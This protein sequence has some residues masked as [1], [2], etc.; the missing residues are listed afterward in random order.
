MS[1]LFL[2]LASVLLLGGTLQA[3]TVT[4]GVE[5]IDYLPCW[6]V[7]NH[8]YTGFAR[9]LFDAFAKDTGTTIVYRPMPVKRLLGAMLTGEVDAKFPDNALWAQDARKS[10]K[11]VYSAGVLEFI[12]GVMVPKANIGRG[13]DT[14]KT[15]ATVRGF[16]PFPYLDRISAGKIAVAEQNDYPTLIEFVVRGRADGVYGSIICATAELKKRKANA[17]ELVFD[18]QLPHDR[19]FYHLSSVTKPDLVQAFDAWLASHADQVKLLKDVS[20]VTL[21]QP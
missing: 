6:G 13:T 11:V 20:G 2:H 14:L 17:Q 7:R 12:D 18:P 21:E 8:E 9:D 19:N 3:A 10:A 5:D 15:L 4:I 1:R 16:T